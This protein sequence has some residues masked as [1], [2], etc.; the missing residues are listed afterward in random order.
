MSILLPNFRVFFW[1]NKNFVTKMQKFSL[2][3][4]WSRNS[5]R[6]RQSNLFLK[7]Q[8]PFFQHQNIIPLPQP[9][10]ENLFIHE[11]GEKY[12]KMTSEIFPKCKSF[13]KPVFVLD[14]LRH[15]SRYH[16]KLRVHQHSIQKF[17]YKSKSRSCT[18]HEFVA[19]A[20]F[21]RVALALT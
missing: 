2:K 20:R 11:K 12:L 1:L 21:K 17:Q 3:A 10:P 18:T 13:S 5:Y 9:S 6:V 15:Q 19:L 8:V 7:S 16:L 4:F 14:V